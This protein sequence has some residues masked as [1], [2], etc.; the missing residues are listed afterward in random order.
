M[1][2]DKKRKTKQNNEFF[3]FLLSYYLID[4]FFWYNER[5][6]PKTKKRKTTG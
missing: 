6:R 5:T 4:Y 1:N 3:S 2:Y